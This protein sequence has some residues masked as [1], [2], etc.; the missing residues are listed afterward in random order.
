MAINGRHKILTLYNYARC[1]KLH[2]TVPLSFS[3]HTCGMVSVQVGLTL[4]RNTWSINASIKNETV[5]SCPSFAALCIMF[6]PT[7][8]FHFRRKGG[9]IT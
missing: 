5:Y 3:H 2:A 1:H 7:K 6:Y 8:E 4:D 9:G